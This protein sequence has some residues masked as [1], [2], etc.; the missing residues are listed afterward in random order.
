MCRVRLVNVLSK[1]SITFH[2]DLFVPLKAL[3][4]IANIL[5]KKIAAKVNKRN[6]SETSSKSRKITKLQSSS[7]KESRTKGCDAIITPTDADSHLIP[8]FS[9]SADL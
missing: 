9:I 3:Q 8:S 1:F 7:K 5:L 2:L 4:C 6:I